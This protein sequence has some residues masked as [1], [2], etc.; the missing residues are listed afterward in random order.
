MTT[1]RAALTDA[2]YR[3]KVGQGR[4]QGPMVSTLP[5]ISFGGIS[6]G[7]A[8]GFL[9][10]ILIGLSSMFMLLRSKLL[11]VTKN[12]AAIRGTH[13][14]VSALAGV[15]LLFHIAYLFIPPISVSMD[16]GYVSVAVA[17]AVW[18]TG[19]AFLE[20]LRDSLFFHG[21]LSSILIGLVM[22]HAATSSV[23][24]PLFLVEAILGTTLVVMVANATYHLNRAVP[25]S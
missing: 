16:L 12:I 11:K 13:V 2:R 10:L 9:A 22:V 14:A 18:L 25:K 24:I 8:S 5:A 20:R 19:T 15:F 21:A 23:N 4:T 6:I 7:D 1:E 17:V 3:R